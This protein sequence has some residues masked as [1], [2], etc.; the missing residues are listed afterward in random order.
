MFSTFLNNVLRKPEKIAKQ[1]KNCFIIFAFRLWFP[2]EQRTEDSG[3]ANLVTAVLAAAHSV[4]SFPYVVDATL[5]W[6]IARTQQCGTE[7]ETKF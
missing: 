5:R 7:E 4:A 6:E 3:G 1:F 2:R